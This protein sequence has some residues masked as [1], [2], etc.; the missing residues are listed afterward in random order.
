M[1]CALLFASTWRV[2]GY[3]FILAAHKDS[4]GHLHTSY[5]DKDYVGEVGDVKKFKDSQN[6]SVTLE[7]LQRSVT[8]FKLCQ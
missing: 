3:T 7:F 4:Q 5:D 8:G 2:N 6:C 1:L